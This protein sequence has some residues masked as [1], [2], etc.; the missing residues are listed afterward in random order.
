MRHW[1]LDRPAMRTT[2][3]EQMQFDPANGSR[4]AYI[5]MT[6][7]FY[8]SG[9][10]RANE[11]LG[12]DRNW[13]PK[14]FRGRTSALEKSV[15]R[16]GAFVKALRAL[17]QRSKQ[18]NSVLAAPAQPQRDRQNNQQSC[19]PHGSEAY[20]RPSRHR[21]ARH[22]VLGL[23]LRCRGRR[24]FRPTSE[25]GEQSTFGSIATADARCNKASLRNQGQP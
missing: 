6:L 14:L 18:P 2:G 25:V 8:L 4:R 7:W 19:F 9:A 21:V 15:P 22:D 11:P 17:P 10:A 20:K 1:P 3:Q 24:R 5:W 13:A 23:E 16:M 12:D